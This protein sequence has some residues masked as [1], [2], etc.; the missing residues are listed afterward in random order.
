MHFQS[1][2]ST[3]TVHELLFADD[4]ALNATSEGDMHRGIDAFATSC[5][6]LGLII[7][8]EETVIMHQLPPDA[9]YVIPQINV[10]G[11][12]LRVVDNFTYLGR[13]INRR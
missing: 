6:N 12:Q 10:N 2:V 8:T 7:N 5:D 11:A 1:R 4:C 13:T 3:T 9:P